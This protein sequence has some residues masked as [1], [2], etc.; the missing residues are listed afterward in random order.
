MIP[1]NP[2]SRRRRPPFWWPMNEPWPP[3]N[4]DFY[5]RQRRNRFARRAGWFSF[6][7]LWA[8]MWLIVAVSRGKVY[9]GDTQVTG[10]V[11]VL[12]V[13]AAVAGI[14]ALIIRWI[15]GPIADIVGA[16]DRIAR[17]DY[18]V[19]VKEP[20]HGPRW[21]RDTA[22]A[23]NSMAGELESQDLAR[24]NLM[25]DIA[26]ELRTPL[27]VIQGRL[28]GLIDGVYSAGPEQLQGLL[29][30]TRVLSRLVEDLR[31]L[32]TAE[33]GALALVKEPTDL[34][35]LVN[36]VISSLSGPAGAAGIALRLDA[37]RAGELQPIS[38]D[39][40]RIREVLTNLAGN[41]IRYTPSGGSVTI[42]L[43]PQVNRVELRV[44]DTGAGISEAEL[45]RIF[46]R[47]YKDAGSAGSGLGLTIA[48]RLVEAH[49]GTIRAESRVGAG[50]TISFDL[51]A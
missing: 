51:P 27:A 39:P 29:E 20:A 10:P 23:F 17:R 47:F 15:S 33:S 48:R 49:G 36:D 1:W 2:Y 22:R 50:T 34:S 26:H 31:L 16:A 30:N 12:I 18:R 8:V 21:A 43:V 37:S 7:P 42:S 24:R 6:W 45:P 19:R 28:E 5:M 32:A 4:R 41:A 9:I 44:T 3:R 14:V 25:A 46:D 35:A 40:V 38:I 13:C 11:G